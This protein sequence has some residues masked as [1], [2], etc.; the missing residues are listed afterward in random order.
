MNKNYFGSW[1][2]FFPEN[3][4]STGQTDINTEKP[5]NYD[6]EIP[7]LEDFQSCN[8]EEITEFFNK[9]RYEEVKICV[10]NGKDITNWTVKWCDYC[11]CSLESKH[12]P[13]HICK[14]CK[15]V[16]CNLC[17][18]EKTEE[19][20]LKNGSKNWKKRKNHLLNCFS[21]IEEMYTEKLRINCDICNC[22]SVNVVR[23]RLFFD[24]E[25]SL[26]TFFI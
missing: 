22:S 25:F 12:H 5:V 20:A 1:F 16:M 18:E 6:K 15:K 9:I 3:F 23:T 21:H 14:L 4:I 19:I 7:T 10:L 8:L 11:N 2:S 17:Y 13:L 24:L 26:K